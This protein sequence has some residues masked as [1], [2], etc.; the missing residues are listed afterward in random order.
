[1][2]MTLTALAIMAI[3]ATAF[4]EGCVDVFLEVPDVV[5]PGD[6]VAV[7]GGITNCGDTPGVAYLVATLTYEGELIAQ[8]DGTVPLAAGETKAYELT[9][10]VVPQEVVPGTYEICV[11]A[12]LDGGTDTA[13]G[14]TVVMDSGSKVRIRAKALQLR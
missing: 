11:T 5:H 7:S 4:A 2:K 13:C 6:V 12:E 10:L 8:V 1:M 3:A 9:D 14:T